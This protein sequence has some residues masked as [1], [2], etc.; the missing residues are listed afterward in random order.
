MFAVEFL[1]MAAGASSAT[2]RA[3]LR[4]RRD[5]EQAGSIGGRLFALPDTPDHGIDGKS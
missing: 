4:D 5:L 3:A 1:Q 2:G